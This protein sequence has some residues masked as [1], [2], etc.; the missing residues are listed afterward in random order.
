MNFRGA[1]QDRW[2]GPP[3]RIFSV[4]NLLGRERCFQPGFIPRRSFWVSFGPLVVRFYEVSFCR[5]WFLMI[6][7]NFWRA[8]SGTVDW[9][10]KL[11][12]GYNF[13]D[14]WRCSRQRVLLRCGLPSRFSSL[15]FVALPLVNLGEGSVGS[16]ILSDGFRSNPRPRAWVPSSVLL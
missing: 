15:L 10:Y 8:G 9:L 2:T 6:V 5:A 14:R 12:G 11:S 7:M 13:F 3:N 4:C 1:A 16:D